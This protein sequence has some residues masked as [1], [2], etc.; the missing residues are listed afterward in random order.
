M[1]IVCYKSIISKLMVQKRKDTVKSLVEIIP[2]VNYIL[3]EHKAGGKIKITVDGNLKAIDKLVALV[4][5]TVN[6]I[7]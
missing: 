6:D 5:G 7:L 1:I 2:G 3:Y 4:Q